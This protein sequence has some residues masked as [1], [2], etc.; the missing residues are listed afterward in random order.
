MT[1]TP[2]IFVLFPK[3]APYLTAPA[4]SLP[5]S[6]RYRTLFNTIMQTTSAY[7]SFLVSQVTF[8]TLQSLRSSRLRSKKKNILVGETTVLM[9]VKESVYSSKNLIKLS[10]V[11][12]VCWHSFKGLIIVTLKKVH[13][14]LDWRK[15]AIP[16]WDLFEFWSFVY[17][18]CPTKKDI[19][20]SRQGRVVEEHRVGRE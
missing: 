9:R 12:A 4:K 19:R 11:N 8:F 10:Q 20:K 18:D 16:A 1:S 3:T 7:Q 13:E 6:H 17:W 15:R 5:S 14:L 2:C